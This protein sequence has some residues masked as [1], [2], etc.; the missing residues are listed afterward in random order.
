MTVGRVLRPSRTGNI[1][2]LHLLRAEGRQD[3]GGQAQAADEEHRVA[4]ATRT[5]KRLA[6]I[7]TIGNIKVFRKPEH[8]PLSI[9][10]AREARVT[11]GPTYLRGV[12]PAPGQ[13]G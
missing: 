2:P 9:H 10:D 4:K 1:D 5:M 7:S 3:G 6:S 11:A 12:L 13:G 8:S